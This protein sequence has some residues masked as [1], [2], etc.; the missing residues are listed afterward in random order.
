VREDGRRSG[1]ARA[2]YDSGE[3]RGSLRK[4]GSKAADTGD[5][6]R[7]N[8]QLPMIDLDAELVLPGEPRVARQA[9]G[10]GVVHPDIVHH[11]AP[12]ALFVIAADIGTARVPAHDD[13]HAVELLVA[14][15]EDVP[16]H[17]RLPRHSSA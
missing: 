10:G 3:A 12:L 4:A 7:R 14:R 8:D 5:F 1:H 9:R 15:V 16:R 11:H 6:I 17:L 13:G 2:S